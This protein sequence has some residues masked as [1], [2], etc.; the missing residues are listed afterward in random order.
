MKIF[1]TGGA[2][3]IG[4]HIAESLVKEGYQIKI[5]DNFSTGKIENLSKISADCEI[6]NGDILDIEKIKKEMKGYDFVS[7]QAAQLEIIRGDSDPEFD[8]RVNTIGTLNVLRAAKENNIKKVVNASSACIYGQT[9]GSTSELFYPKP[10]WAYGVSKLAAEKYCDIYNDYHGLPAVNLRYAITYGEKEWFRR[11][12]TIFIKRAI[13]NLPLVIFGKGEQIRDFVYVGDVVRFHNLC[14]FDQRADGQAFNVG[15]GIPTSIEQLAEK[16]M[17]ASNKKLDIAYEDIPEGELSQLVSDKKRNSSELKKMI[18]DIS[19]AQDLI[20]W[21][22][23]MSLLE[24]LRK[25]IKWAS[26]NLERWEKIY[27]S[28]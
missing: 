21:K 17:E 14:L 24:G 11:V 25:E 6:V 20:D 23:E 8:L 16:V 19:K 12:L 26:E 1:I 15:T 13:Q 22:P 2:G 10:N 18:L 9:D 3:F 28:I 5:Y 7:H 4:S 27:Y